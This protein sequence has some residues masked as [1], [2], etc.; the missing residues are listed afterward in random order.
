[1]TLCVT[2]PNEMEMNAKMLSMVWRNFLK[3]GVTSHSAQAASLPH[4]VRRCEREKI[5]YRITAHPGQGYTIE[6]I[7]EQVK[8]ED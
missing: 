3:G 5:P 6:R 1:M 8:N 4:I 7:K 2:S